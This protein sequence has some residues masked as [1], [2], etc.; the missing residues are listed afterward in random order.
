VTLPR[1]GEARVSVVAATT[2]IEVVQ[3]ALILGERSDLSYRFE[4]IVYL[5]GAA[6]RKVPYERS[7]KLQLL[8]AEPDERTLVPL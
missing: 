6:R 3:Q 8:P 1:L 4:G 7:G 2:L 5:R